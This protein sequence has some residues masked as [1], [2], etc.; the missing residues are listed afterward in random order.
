MKVE[1]N[2]GAIPRKAFVGAIRHEAFVRPFP[3]ATA[4]PTILLEAPM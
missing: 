1:V 2:M 4:L 3:H